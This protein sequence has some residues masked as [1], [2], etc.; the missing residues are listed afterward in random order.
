MIV[1]KINQQILFLLHLDIRHLTF[2]NNSSKSKSKIFESNT[3]RKV[4]SVGS[5]T[6]RNGISAQLS[7]LGKNQILLLLSA[8]RS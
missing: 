4:Y 7:E 1:L 5:L 3:L 6:G 8:S 2:Q